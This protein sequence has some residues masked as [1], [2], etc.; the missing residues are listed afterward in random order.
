MLSK[1]LSDLLNFGNDKGHTE[2]IS[3]FKRHSSEHPKLIIHYSTAN[4]PLLRIWE[5]RNCICNSVEMKNIV[6]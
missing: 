6:Y 3:V 1:N 2:R 4:Y 5:N